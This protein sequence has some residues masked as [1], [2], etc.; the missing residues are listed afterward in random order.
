MPR[1][2]RSFDLSVADIE[3]IEEALRARGRELCQTPCG[4]RLRFGVNL[5]ETEALSINRRLCVTATAHSL[6]KPYVT[7]L[8]KREDEIDETSFSVC[9]RGDVCICLWWF[10][11]EL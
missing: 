6:I 11:D 9:L 1:F 5:R 4:G 2:N 3:L 8:A 10:I 7:R